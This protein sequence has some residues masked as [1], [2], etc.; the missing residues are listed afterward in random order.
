MFTS[1]LVKIE[2]TVT[3]THG[4]YTNQ[5]FLHTVATKISYTDKKRHNY[6]FDTVTND[7]CE[8]KHPDLN[9][10]SLSAY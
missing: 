9:G 5:G 4:H 3:T 1:S 8:P 7:N 6:C 10:S 2:N